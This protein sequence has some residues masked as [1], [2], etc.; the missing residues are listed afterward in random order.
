MPAQRSNPARAGR[1]PASPPASAHDFLTPEFKATADAADA[2][3]AAQRQ[4]EA[5]LRERFRAWE[6]ALDEC[7]AAHEAFEALLKR[8]AGGERDWRVDELVES[9]ENQRS[10]AAAAA[11]RAA[12]DAFDAAVADT[13]RA[14]ARAEEA[15]EQHREA[16]G[17]ALGEPSVPPRQDAAPAPLRASQLEAALRLE[18][19]VRR[20]I[21][22]GAYCAELIGRA[23]ALPDAGPWTAAG[24]PL[25]D[26]LASGLEAGLPLV[27]RVL[28]ADAVGPSLLAR[29]LLAEA[30]EGAQ[31]DGDR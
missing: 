14:R 23:Q 24:T 25:G 10:L 1:A 13:E 11:E 7:A 26:M 21:G 30:P 6:A 31:S 18:A 28:L 8:D 20:L 15:F 4:S 29:V 2:A 12:F 27:A 16:A 9:P 5:V 3:R 22:D 17:R 19:G